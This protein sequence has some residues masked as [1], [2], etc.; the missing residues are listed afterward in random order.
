MADLST[1]AATGRTI[2]S[3]LSRAREQWILLALLLALTAG[4]W[5][6]SV[7]QSQTMDVSMG[8]VARGA[9]SGDS[10]PP[11]A[12][13]ADQPATDSMAGMDMGDA[14]AADVGELAASGMAGM[15]NGGW[16]WAGFSAF[17]VAWAVMMAAMMFPSVTPMV[18]FHQKLAAGRRSR[19]Q[20]YVPTWVFVTGYLLVW[21]TV[22]VA[23]WF[24]VQAVSELAGRIGTASRETWGPLA[25]GGVLVLAGVYQFTSIKGVCLRHCQ[26][27]VGFVMTHW[28]D[29]YRGALR[30][31]IVHGAFCLGC[32]WAL[33]VVLVAAGVMSLGWMLLLT[34][35][36]FAEKV[37]FSS[38]RAT[39]AIGIAFLS[40]G[41]VVAAGAL[42][43]P[44]IA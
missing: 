37:L 10:P 22:G 35:V 16:S 26:S 17:L 9:A 2:A 40:L 32:C 23:T 18:L 19:G 33:F 5:A 39:Q 20:A 21:T 38:P 42:D 1:Q 34:L 12:G 30:M 4:S 13:N 28:R 44:W 41:L 36:V 29:G 14:P 7:H 27:P 43:M 15:G 31:G 11:A 6:L 8:V 3:V 24:A 25:L